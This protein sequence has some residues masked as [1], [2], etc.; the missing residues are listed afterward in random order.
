MDDA[1]E[2]DL[3]QQEART[4]GRRAISK[5]RHTR[6]AYYCPGL[7]APRALGNPRDSRAESSETR[8]H[9]ASRL[10]RGVSCSA[11]ITAHG[12]PTVAPMV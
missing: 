1:T 2:P 6:L 5:D 9:A 11:Q 7:C 4:A 12:R 3:D 10:W 8:L